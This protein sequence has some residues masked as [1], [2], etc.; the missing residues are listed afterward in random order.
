M[1]WSQGGYPSDWRSASVSVASWPEAVKQWLD[2]QKCFSFLCLLCPQWETARFNSCLT[3]GVGQQTASLKIIQTT[4]VKGKKA[5]FPITDAL[6]NC[7]VLHWPFLPL[8]VDL[9]ALRMSVIPLSH[10]SSLIRLYMFNTEF[11]AQILLV[12]LLQGK[13]EE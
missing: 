11:L 6:P 5:C 7:T 13:S 2:F 10:P 8:S 1:P 9:I 4:T 3:F 12:K